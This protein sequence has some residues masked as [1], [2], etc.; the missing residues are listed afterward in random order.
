M[1][2]PEK[3]LLGSTAGSGLEID[4]IDDI[5]GTEIKAEAEAEIEGDGDGIE[6][7]AGEKEAESNRP[8]AADRPLKMVG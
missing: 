1:L 7:E 8:V 2:V 3:S 4:L 6:M 5:E